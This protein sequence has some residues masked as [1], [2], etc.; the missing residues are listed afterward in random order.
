MKIQEKFFYLRVMVKSEV[1]IMSTFFGFLLKLGYLL[2][3]KLPSISFAL[4]VEIVNQAVDML[5]GVAYFIPFATLIPL[6]A[7]KMAIINFRIALAVLKF[8]KSF[9]PGIS[10]G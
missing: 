4:P 6:F 9:I 3:D 2:I 8:V 7:L 5:T 10:G 1:F